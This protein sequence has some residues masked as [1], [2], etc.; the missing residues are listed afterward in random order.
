MQQVGKDL[1]ALPSDF[2]DKAQYTP[3]EY[4]RENARQKA[5]VRAQSHSA[6]AV[7]ASDEGRCSWCIDGL[8]IRRS[9]SD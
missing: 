6:V 1:F 9:T 7:Q 8:R 4:V 5:L 3:T 2:P